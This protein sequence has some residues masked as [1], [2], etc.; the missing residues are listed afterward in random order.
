MKS[1]FEEVMKERRSIRT[2]GKS[3]HATR[4]R[5]EEILKLALHAPSSY[6]AQSSRMVVLMGEAGE[7]FWAI[8][9]EELRKVTPP[10]AFARTVKK[11]DGFRDGN[12]TILFYEDTAVTQKLKKDFPLYEDKFE[13]WAQHNNAMLE[14]AVWLTLCEHGIAASLQ[15]YNP[16]VDADAA[17]EWN[18][19]A[20]WTLIAQMPFGKA[21]EQTP[22]KNFQPFDQTVRFYE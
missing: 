22:P 11:L 9:Q 17:K 10:E 20:D 19:P 3:N 8:A 2:L 13:Q 15:H 14:Y 4:E 1:R 6:N 7:R 5:L 12:G 18:I 16:L 21:E